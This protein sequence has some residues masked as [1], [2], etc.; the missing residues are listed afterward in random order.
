MPALLESPKT[1]NKQQEFVEK[2]IEQARQ[3]IRLLD[4]FSAGLRALI[5]AFAFLFAALLVDH[6]VE[7]PAGS[8]WAALTVFIAGVAGY[9]YLTLYRPGRRQINP[10]YAAR[11]VEHNIPDAKNSVINYIDLKDDEKVPGSVMAAI[12]VRAA[13][14]LRNVDLNRVIQRKQVVWLASIAGLFFAAAVVAVFLPP[15]RTA[16][17]LLTPKQ[18]DTTILQG[19]D[20]RLEVEL[21]GRIPAKT[22]PDA[23]RV[24]LWYNPEDPTTYEERPLELVEGQKKVLGLTVPAKQ[25]RNGFHYIVLAGNA[26][27]AEFEVKV[28]IIPQFTGWTVE[29]EFPK[30]MN[31]PPEKR[32]DPRLV[33]CYNTIVTLTAL[34]NRPVKSGEIVIENQIQTIPG[35]L[36]P[37]NPEAIVFRIPMLRDGYYRVHFV[38]TDG[39]SNPDPPRNAILLEDPKPQFRNFDVTYVYPKYLRAEPVTINVKQPDL[40]ALR[41]TTVTLVAHANRPVKSAS[42]EFPGNDK[43]I[44]GSLDPQNPMQVKFALPPMM[45]DGNY[46]ISFT[47]ETDEKA[48]ASDAFKVRVLS[49]D[50]PKVFISKPQEPLIDLPANGV[51]AVEGGATDDVGIAEMTLH[52]Q[53]VSEKPEINLVAKRYRNG[54]SFR[55]ESDGSYPTQLEY[56]D[57]VD[58]ATVKQ[59]GQAGAGFALK[60]DMIVEYWL[61]AVDI[62]D[63]PPGPNRDYSIHQ[64]VKITEPV[65]KKDEDKLRQQQQEK[66]KLEQAQQQHEKNQDQK[67]QKEE[68]KAPQPQPK[69][70]QQRR[71]ENQKQQGD[72]QQPGEQQQQ[73]ANDNKGQKKDSQPK[74]GGENQPK[75]GNPQPQPDD[76]ELQEQDKKVEQANEAQARNNQGTKSDPNAPPPKPETGAPKQDPM[77]NPGTPKQDPMTNPGAPKQDPM[78]N[79]GA[80]KQDPMTNPGTPKP[81]MGDKTTPQSKNGGTGSDTQPQQ[82]QFSKPQDFNDLADKLDSNDPKEREQ[83]REQIKKMMDQTGKNQAKPQEQEDQTKKMRDKLDALEKEKFDHSMKRIE[84]EKQKLQKEKAEREKRVEQA[85]E[86]AKSDDPDKHAEGQKEMEKELQNQSTRD[87]VEQQLQRLADGTKDEKQR[88]NLDNARTASRNNVQ[89]KDAAQAPQRPEKDDTD[90]LAK[91][92]Q[93]G[94]PEEKQEAKDQLEKKLQ[95]P[96]QRDQV[97]KDLENYKN[98]LPGEQRKDFEQQMKQMEDDA[99]RKDPAMNQPLPKPNDI[100]KLAEDLKSND[101]KTKEQARDTL[102][103]AMDEAKKNPPKP[104]KQQQDLDKHRDSLDPLEKQNFDQAMQDVQK[105]MQNLQREDRVKSAAEK[106]KSNDPGQRAQGQKEIE[107]ELQNPDTRDDVKRELQQLAGD[108]KDPNQKRNLED[109]IN[110]SRE[111]VENQAAKQ[112]PKK[113]D[114]DELAKKLQKGTP[115][116]QQEAQDKLQKKLQ[117]PNQSEQTKKDLDNFAKGLPDDQKKDFDKKMQQMKNDVANKNSGGSQTTPKPKDIEKLAKQLTS[118][119]KQERQDAQRQLEDAMK[120]ADKDP[121]ASADAKKEIEKVRDGIK[122][123]AKKDEFDKAM[124][125]ID[126]AVDKQRQDQQAADQKAQRQTAEQIAN[127]LSSGDPAKEQA[128]QQKLEDALKDPKN[129]EAVK[130]ELDKVKKNADPAAKKKID[131]AVHQ[132][133][134]K[135]AKGGDQAGPKKEK[136]GPAQP[137]K[138]DLRKL[139]EDLNSKDA[140]RQKTAQDKLEEMLKDQ[141]SRQ[142]I[143]DELAKIGKENPPAKP[144]IDDALRK[145]EENLAK[146]DADKTPGKSGNVVDNHDGKKPADNAAENPPPGSLPD[147]KNKFKAGELTLK[148]FEKNI[149]KEEF[150]KQLGWTNEQIAA[151]MTKKEQQLKALNSQIVAVEKGDAPQARVGKTSLN[152]PPERIVVDPKE[153]SGTNAGGKFTAPPGLSDPYRRFTEEGSGN[154]QRTTEPKR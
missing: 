51:L 11:Q 49:D 52:M 9:L 6:Y 1:V 125:Q 94:T 47:P 16:L 92:T 26:R 75:A 2:Q 91:K 142:A 28:H 153:T 135:I 115:A 134:E 21:K 44:A 136:D 37:D 7:T 15:T 101:A 88:K 106:A 64:R 81:D 127:G 77:T 25:V 116:E 34:T 90:K 96:K 63:V 105:E 95:D 150:R 93:T 113:N 97:R 100:Q 139:A 4:W 126:K 48:G 32:D 74:T 36:D 152:D 17:V 30:Y 8:G 68:R 86:K 123:Q 69:G 124:Q 35:T 20:F 138:D 144:A 102:R 43:P 27:S 148:Q 67:N 122:D 107:K 141:Q 133:E 56:K 18:G 5:G 55:R 57:F 10:I 117:D 98:S 71:Q 72:Q 38:T 140:G 39:H 66:K 31:R 40:E 99:A 112:P 58:L 33:G 146:K 46:R 110:A 70:D 73:G 50:K 109:A 151:Y 14:D 103:Q 22:D 118:E 19:E 114:T 59:D 130:K 85:A 45:E 84:E 149:T 61:E 42:V 82:G 79:P 13:R 41:G 147:L 80:P 60:K 104:E 87:D 121:G 137:N 119:D 29:Y 62:C 53:V 12:G 132:A 128:A 76:P 145:A 143:K 3:R 23:A 120:K 24:R 131:D 83:A 129:S 89:K 108:T 78:T 65:T 111:N 154:N 54:V